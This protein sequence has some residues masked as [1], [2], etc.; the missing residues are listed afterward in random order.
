MTRGRRGR[1]REA[2]PSAR[3]EMRVGVGWGGARVARAHGRM[4][5]WAHGHIGAS[6]HRHIG[7]SAHRRIGASA[8]RR[9]GASAH[10]HA[11]VWP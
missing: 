4:G 8:H 9:I 11:A 1:R 3:L 5:A 7:A 6:A 2:R 10:R